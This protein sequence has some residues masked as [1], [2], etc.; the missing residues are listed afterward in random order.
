MSRRGISTSK[1]S[2]SFYH[3]INS[4]EQSPPSGASTHSASQE[5]SR[6]SWDPK[7]HYRAHK[8]TPVRSLYWFTWL[9][10]K[11]PFN[12]FKF[13][14]NII[15]SS[16]PKSFN[17]SLP[18]T[19]SDQYFVR[20]SHIYHAYY[21]AHPSPLHLLTLII[22]GEVHKLWSSSLCSLLHPL[23]QV[24]PHILLS[25]CSQTLWIYILPEKISR[26]YKTP[27][28]IMFLYQFVY[29]FRQETGRKNFL[30]RN[31]VSAARI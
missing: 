5:N 31:V 8:S 3:S 27:R 15:L 9:V 21:M 4:T 1:D 11:F 20:I 2:L 10:Y 24:G 29:V 30:N 17:W 23:T 26:S 18:F 16:K 25:T 19:F 7:V 12:S 22:F 14:S 13:R 6:L 28:T